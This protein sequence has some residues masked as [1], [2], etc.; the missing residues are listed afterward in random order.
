MGH[1]FNPNI[2]TNGLILNID[3]SNIRSYPGSGTIINDLSGR[4]AHG[5]MNGTI[6]YV[7]AGGN[8]D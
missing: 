8:T 7:G 3:A 1:Y 6:T 5:T 2:V 4:D